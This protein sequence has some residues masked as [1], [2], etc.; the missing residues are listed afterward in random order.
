M[1]RPQEVLVLGQQRFEPADLVIMAIVNRTNT[2]RNHDGLVITATLTI[3][4]LFKD[5]EITT[6]IRTTKFIIERSTT[7]RT[8]NHDL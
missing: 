7:Q 5:T 1:S 8:F 3:D 6:Q 4:G 2:T